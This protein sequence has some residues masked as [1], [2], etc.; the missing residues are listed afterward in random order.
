MDGALLLLYAIIKGMTNK[1]K[2]TILT[3]FVLLAG[4]IYA[5]DREYR[6][7]FPKSTGAIIEEP[8]AKEIAI[9]DSIKKM[10]D[11]LP[12]S[13]NLFQIESYNYTNG[14]FIVR[15]SVDHDISYDFYNWLE[16]S[17]YSQIPAKMFEI[18]N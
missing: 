4:L 11:N 10:K 16:E 5:V 8:P 1:K 7:L 12:I 6:I 17:E 15:T 3:F 9:G 2:I 18:I 13:T 14:N